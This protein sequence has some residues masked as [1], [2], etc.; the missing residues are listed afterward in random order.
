MRRGAKH[1][2]PV[3]GARRTFTDGFLCGTLFLSAVCIKIS[4][5]TRALIKKNEKDQEKVEAA[6]LDFCKS[7][8]NPKLKSVCYELEPVKRH[9]SR[10]YLNGLPDEAICRRMGKNNPQICTI[11][12]P[13]QITEDMNFSK[14]RVKE[15]KQILAEIDGTCKGCT[16]KEDYVNAIQ[17]AMGW[18]KDL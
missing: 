18:K 9:Y 6:L 11:K 8:T 15:L 1:L 3:H 10:H 17:V 7:A 2:L 13:K 12:F 4:E 14:M 5:G 16:A